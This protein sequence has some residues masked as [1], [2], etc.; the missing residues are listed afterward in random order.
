MSRMVLVLGIH[1]QWEVEWEGE[2]DDGFLSGM[3]RID[4]S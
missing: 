2:A 3:Q 4:L 1:G